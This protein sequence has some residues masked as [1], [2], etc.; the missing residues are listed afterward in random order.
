MAIPIKYNIG[1]LM[2]RKVSAVMTVLGIGIVIAVM[3]AMMAL[4]NGVQQA[5]VTSGSKD[6][7]LVLR[8]GA[9][10]EAT[11]WVS[12][13]R[14]RII[15]ALPG[16]ERGSDGPL[17]SPETVVIFKLPRHDNPTGSNVNVRGV[18][19]KALEIRPYIKLLEGRM[20]R[21]GLYEVIVTRRMQKRFPNMN[22]G[23]TFKSGTYTWTVVGVF[24]ADGTSFDSE[25]W[26]PVDQLNETQ[27][28][29]DYSSVLLKPVD[30]S[31]Y[32]SIKDTVATDT[33]LKLL[34]KS[35]HQYYE[36]QTSGLMGIQILVT[37]VT[38]F[39]VL[40]ATLGAMNTMFSA[41]A[42]R[43]RELATMRALGFK[44]RDILLSIV[45]EAIVVSGLAGVVGVILALPVNGIATGT[46]NF[47]TFS[48][49]AFNFNISLEVALFAIGLAIVAGVI[50]GL[51][52][53]ISAARL[54]I[55]RALREI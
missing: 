44:R 29:E 26:A 39:M 2:S 22:I 15:S 40:G 33:R 38:F 18:T 51:L 16:I 17:I 34:T 37:I 21:P 42:S 36:D 55:T 45:I 4:Y 52:P 53:A 35:E 48:E 6:N 9:Q 24:D 23:D 10:T 5:L 12:R 49:V 46:A 47:V 20:V 3:V 7:L 19:P 14:Y 28:R 50:G 32:Q 1:N 31:A 11:S 41:V 13:D 43:K 25:I 30:A 27:K 54:P 8:E